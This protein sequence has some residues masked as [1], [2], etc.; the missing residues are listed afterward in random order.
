[1]A[2]IRHSFVS[3]IAD[4]P[5]PTVI[6]PSNWNENHIVQGLVTSINGIEP[7]VSGAVT[8]PTQY[9]HVQASAA[10]TWTIVHNLGKYPSIVVIDSAGTRYLVEGDAEFPNENTVILHFSA[11]F[12]GDA[13]LN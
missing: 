10:A 1:M 3:L 9:H 4:D 11:G 2:E 12:A 6:R 8:L 5:D 7:D 13:Y